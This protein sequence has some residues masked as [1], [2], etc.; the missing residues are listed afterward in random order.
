[1]KEIFALIILDKGLIS[2]IYKIITKINNHTIQKSYQKLR[3]EMLFM[4]ISQNT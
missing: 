2:K 1:M 4:S 3:E